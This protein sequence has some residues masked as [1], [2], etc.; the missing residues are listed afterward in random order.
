[1]MLDRY[2]YEIEDVILPDEK[3]EL[4]KL[5]K[6]LELYKLQ[7]K[8]IKEELEKIDDRN[9]YKLTLFK[10]RFTLRMENVFK[11]E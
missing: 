8:I 3:N 1:M 6:E 9:D 7:D 11:N 2:D 5:K 10:T 4:L